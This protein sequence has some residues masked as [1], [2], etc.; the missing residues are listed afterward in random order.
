[1]SKNMT[2][3]GLAFG[4][5]VAL[6]SSLFAGAPAQ[7]SNV[8]PITL[9][10]NGGTAAG[11]TYTSIIGAGITL[12]ATINPALVADAA[13]NALEAPVANAIYIVSNPS[14]AKISIEVANLTARHGF[15]VYNADGDTA[16]TATG[17][18]SQTYSTTD[19][20]TVDTANPYVDYTDGTSKATYVTNATRIAVRAPIDGGA[21]NKDTFASLFVDS[22]GSSSVAVTVQAVTDT[23]GAAA[24]TTGKI[25]PFENAS[26]AQVVTLLPVSAVSATTTITGLDRTTSG[27][28][29][30]VFTA[31]TV[32]GQSVNPHA[33]RLNT[34]ATLFKDG[35]AQT[36]DEDSTAGGANVEKLQSG[37][38]SSGRA[39]FSGWSDDG[40]ARTSFGAGIYSVQA[41]FRATGTTTFVQVGAASPVVDLNNGLVANIDN[42][43]A[44]AVEGA[45]VDYASNSMAVRTGTNAAVVTAKARNS[46]NADIVSSGI[47]FRA[48]VT[49]VTLSSASTVAVS[50]S[51][52]SLA[53]K[54][55]VAI[56]F[57]TSDSAG[58][59]TFTLTNAGARNTDRVTIAIEALKADGTYT[60]AQTVTV[61][62]ANAALTT[63]SAVPGNYISGANPTLTLRARDQFGQ[64]INSTANGTLS[65][66]AVARVGGLVDRTKLAETKTM[67]NGAASFTF[68]NF[69]TTA[70]PAQVEATLFAGTTQ[71][72]GIT[73]PITINVYNTLATD[74]ITVLDSYKSDITYVDYVVGDETVPAIA[75]QIALTG[76]GSAAGATITGSVQNA[77]AVGQPGA[78]VVIAADGILFYD[79]AAGEYAKD[80]ITTYTNE[81]GTYSVKAIANKVNTAGH[82]V[83][84]TSGGKTATT[85]FRTYL[86]RD[87]LTANNLQ[88]TWDLPATLVKNTTYALTATLTDKW[89]NPVQ[90]SGAGSIDFQGTGSVEVNG[91][92]TTVTRNFDRNGKATVFIRSVKDIAGPGSVT[93]SIKSVASQY[94]VDPALSGDS[95]GFDSFGSLASVLTDV[96]STAWDETKFSKD[97]TAVVDIKDVAPVTGKVNVGSFNGKLVV[98]ASG[99][100]GSRISW[101]VG[102]NWGTG[103]ATSNYSIFNRPTPRAGAT[104]SVEVFVN[105]VKQL[106]KSVVTR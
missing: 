32:Y 74:R 83:T 26:A 18:A 49:A 9:L 25:G 102:G 42:V 91:V 99:L 69:A 21:S 41:Y 97:L 55:D 100:N 44:Y 72:A 56:A 57:G 47:R 84:I 76:I 4:A 86:P 65:V 78:E 71:V 98:Y 77:N 43:D 38:V 51:A 3:K 45:N 58:L 90:T 59:V 88:L 17:T 60:A 46:S 28:T 48:T 67:T 104:V 15:L 106:T 23:D 75:A 6:G 103:V 2:R 39:L 14:G 68:A 7:A 96:R 95:L 70:I 61:T 33:V 27:G 10:P 79:A 94:A 36:L 5:I 11:A 92:A 63:F 85:L 29:Q 37:S 64:P 66:T 89:G 1:M 82:R 20:G 87:L 53:A 13:N 19:F 50:G 35:V 93:A 30:G 8:G 73:N 24:T 52:T 101:K 16:Q 105:G 12:T 62:W 54:D 31:R 40:A 81:F 34:F 22:F 80:K